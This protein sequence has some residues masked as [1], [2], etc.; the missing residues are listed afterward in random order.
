MPESKQKVRLPKSSVVNKSPELSAMTYGEL[1]INYAAGTGNSFLATKKADDT[2]AKFPESASVVN[3][4]SHKVDKVEG[5][6]LSTNDYTTAE[7]NKLAGI[8]SGAEENVQS[9]WNISSTTDDAYI[10]NK[11]TKLSQFTNDAGY[12]TSAV[13]ALTYF[14]TSADVVTALANKSDILMCEFNGTALTPS[15]AEIY[16]AYLNG[17]VVLCKHQENH[18][19][20]DE[21]VI[22]YMTSIKYDPEL[23]GDFNGY[24][25][26][27]GIHEDNNEDNQ[28]SVYQIIGEQYD[29]APWTFTYQELGDL[30]YALHF[31]HNHANKA[32]LD[33]IPSSIA[34]KAGKVLTVNSAA[35]GF[36]FES[37]PTSLSAMTNDAGFITSAVTN[38]SNYASSGDVVTALGAKVDK[39]TGKGLST[40]DYTTEEKNKLS[41][42]QANAQVNGYAFKTIK[43]GG[44]TV[45][46][47]S[48]AETLTLCGSTYI[49][50]TA[51]NST[52][53]K[54]VTISADGLVPTGRTI[55]SKNLG[56]DVILNA[57]DVGALSASTKYAASIDL[58][59]DDTTF[60]YTW[61]LKDQYG[62]NLGAAQLLD[63]PIESV[64]VGGQYIAS[65]K[66]VQ[67][68]LKS[69]STIEFSVADLISGLQPEINST[70]KLNADL[71]EDGTIN[72]VY[73]A[74][75]QA[76]LAGIA[77]GAEVN[78]QADWA[79]TNSG[80]DAYIINKPTIPA[81]ANN[82]Y[83]EITTATTGMQLGNFSANQDTNT[84][85]KLHQVAL[86]GSYND[87]SNK[88]D[89]SNFIT[90]S[91]TAM[92]N[93]AT[94]ANVVSELDKKVET[95]EC[96]FTFTP[97]QGSEEAFP[98][99]CTITCNKTT[100]EIASAVEDGKIVIA[101]SD[102]NDLLDVSGF[103]K[104]YWELTNVFDVEMGDEESNV[105]LVVFSVEV[106]ALGGFVYFQVFG[107]LGE[108]GTNDV[109]YSEDL[110][111]L[112]N[113]KRVATGGTLDDL[114]DA[115]IYNSTSGQVLQYNGSKWVNGT[116]PSIP[117]VSNFITSA[118][119]DLQ[120]FATSSATVNA[121]ATHAASASHITTSER[122]TWNGKQ[123]SISDL[124]QIRS[125]AASGYSA[126]TGFTAHSANTTIHLT[127]AEKTKLGNLTT[128]IANASSSGYMSSA[129]YT[130]LYGIESGAEVNVQ[131][132]WNV[133]D[134]SSDAY[135]QNK[136]TKLSDFTNDGMFITSAVTAM[137]NY[138]TSANVVTALSG[139]TSQTIN[140]TY[141]QLRQLKN[142]SALIPGQSYKITDYT[143][144]T[145][146]ANTSV[147]G[148]DFDIVVVAN[149]ISTL[150]C[151]A[152]AIQHSGDTYF[153]GDALS[154]WQIW[155]DIDNE[156]NKYNWA[157]YTTGK[158]V[159]Y[160]MIDEVG[161][162]C[163][164]D[165]KNILFSISGKPA[166]AYT[167]TLYKNGEC[168]DFSVTYNGSRCRNNIIKKSYGAANLSRTMKLG[169]NVFYFTNEHG[170][171]S[172]NFLDC[173]CQNNVFSG[174]SISFNILERDCYNNNICGTRNHFS[175]NCHD[176]TLLY[177]CMNNIF[178]TSCSNNI[179]SSHTLNNIF[180]NECTNNTLGNNCS[181]NTFGNGCQ[182]NT[183]GGNS[184][185]NTFGNYST[186]IT[187]GNGSNQYGTFIEN[188]II[189]NGCEYIKLYNSN[190]ANQ[191]NILQNISIA[192]GVKGTISNNIEIST[193]SRNLSYTT[194]VA[195]NSNGVLKIYNEA[196]LVL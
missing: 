9:D 47:G 85:V 67:L 69:G 33:K 185:A 37:I 158:G 100:S 167:F 20:G 35:N 129:M 90:S 84:T 159:I 101:T 127:S 175:I 46:A 41:G 105:Q 134:S 11:P 118:V 23:S 136:P 145:G 7:K 139:K 10:K 59:K 133:T 42:I 177:G 188:V 86:T 98:K 44:A 187:F 182:F 88:P 28:P 34:G 179:L 71:I 79:E 161:N 141:S 91:V 135:I 57:T 168:S 53:A 82:G 193:I 113:L 6:G 15:V 148:H 149:S 195:R 114:D 190:A 126:Y 146:L 39:E 49:S 164:Y 165:F 64:V 125:N 68:V 153:N 132:D 150:D 163:P 117:D 89:L 77:S 8:E 87:L 171:S 123:D 63:L 73:T 107:M 52:G 50:L 103:C 54:K 92:T 106:F 119:T 62:N 5:K 174:D 108:W 156:L 102:L 19:H 178:A 104:S 184:N 95:F 29:N 115:V 183:L 22:S 181:Y 173:E 99:N 124:A 48:S 65:A 80:S 147:A 24:I 94:S 1:Y 93:Y 72:K 74:T 120:F 189:G 157:D 144:T 152:K 151:K 176:N 43:A 191:N 81:A 97:N 194:K 160:R 30:Y 36:S 40:N 55:N 154:R 122:T 170:I 70:H 121:L 186:N 116:L 25:Q 16:E 26:F 130:K 13:S 172:Y 143:T 138:A 162:D 3:A 60:Q 38:L 4:L 166:N 192:P 14:A 61:Q 131:S 96:E 27:I 75:E 128:S 196:D 110:L 45:D 140:V 66:T 12:I 21:D 109:V 111:K 51:S 180:G 78:V 17:K 31:A 112:T 155:Y 2:I 83:L 18:S 169:F 137:T 76:K 142:N 58:I 56:S 32:I